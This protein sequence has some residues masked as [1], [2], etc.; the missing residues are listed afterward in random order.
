MDVAG[1][2]ADQA[3]TALAV[4]FARTYVE[5]PSPGA[6]APFLAEGARVGG[7]RQG[8]GVASRVAQAEVRRDS[9]TWRRPGDPHRRLRAPRRAHRFISP[10]RSPA[11]GRERWRLRARPG[12]SRRRA[13]PG[14]PPSG[15]G[16]SPAPTP[17]AIR[18]L[19]DEVHARLPRGALGPGTSPTCWRPGASVVPLAGSLEL[20]GAPG[21]VS[22]LGDGEGAR[23]TVVVAC[24]LRDPSSRA[25]YRLAYRLG[26]IKRNRWYV[27]SVE[28]G[29]S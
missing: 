14:S 13:R 15:P 12:W 17:R 29:L 22:Q 19:V 26:V 3:S 2:A 10:S 16:R 18:S 28:G 23:R 8:A 25:V 11:R 4:R 1:T 5:H 7:G 21:A 24:R 6:L 27:E 9:K 20:L